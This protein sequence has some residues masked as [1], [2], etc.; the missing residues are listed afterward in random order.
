M[1]CSRGRDTILVRDTELLTGLFSLLVTVWVLTSVFYALDLLDQRMPQYGEMPLRTRSIETP[2]RGG[3][4]V[5]LCSGEAG[6]KGLLGGFFFVSL[7]GGW[8]IG[9]LSVFTG[10][11]VLRQHV[12]CAQDSRDS[13]LYLLGFYTAVPV[14]YLLLFK[15]SS[16]FYQ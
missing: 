3:G 6:L 12:L 16:W 14:Y 1:F 5:R 8:L 9:V 7:I 2:E 11:C 13:L 4:T 15:L 10:G